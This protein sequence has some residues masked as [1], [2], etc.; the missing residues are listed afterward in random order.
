[1]R[2]GLCDSRHRKGYRGS[3]KAEFDRTR[4]DVWVLEASASGQSTWDEAR[5]LDARDSYLADE[6]LSNAGSAVT[7]DHY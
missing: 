6:F 2:H 4:P 7:L 1:M 5:G 3:A